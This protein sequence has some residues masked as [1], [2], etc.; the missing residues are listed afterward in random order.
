MEMCNL[1]INQE[2]CCITGLLAYLV[3][4]L[5]SKSSVKAVNTV[6]SVYLVFELLSKS[7][8]KAV[9]TVFSRYLVFEPL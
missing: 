2:L 3:F 6:F 1:V 9:N 4:E 5:L 7:S 8:V